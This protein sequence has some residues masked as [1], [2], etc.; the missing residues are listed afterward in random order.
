MAG[1]DD[2]YRTEHTLARDASESGSA[3][4]ASPATWFGVAI[5]GLMTVFIGLGIDAWRHNNGAGEESLLSLSNPG[6]L[7]A[8]I[9]LL[10]TSLGALGGFTASMLRGVRSAE[11]A[12][13][14]FA[15]VTAAW[16]AVAVAGIGSIVYIGASGVTVGHGEHNEAVAADASHGAPGGAAVTAE[17]AGDIANAL[18]KEGLLDD[19]TDPNAVPG[20][21]TRGATGAPGGA[22]DRGQHATFTQVSTMPAGEDLLNLFP[23]G[24]VTADNLPLLKD[25]IEQV[26]Q[27]ALQY[28]TVEAAN[29]GGFVVTTND[30]P[31]M[32]MHFLNYDNVRDG[33]F[34]P[35]KPEGLLFSKIDGGEPKLVGVWFL[36]LPGI[37]GVTREVEPAGFASDLDLWHA[38]IGLCLGGSVGASE[39]ETRESCEGK[40]GRFTA[41][42]RWMMHVWVAPEATENPAG[43]F[44]YLNNDL[45]KKQT[46]AKEAAPAAPSGTVPQ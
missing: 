1:M 29:A 39:G 27:V 46:A 16:V 11:D 38:H 33:K 42:L 40:G 34:D 41:D 10:V 14:R 6:H 19:G 43:V 5:V 24:I 20:A 15:P 23:K 31:F 13:R 26:R 21:L 32:G 17:E 28:P 45:Y 4:L 25:Q 8:G 22:H 18:E 2:A 7:I 9:G 35:S 36:L 12:I 44:A 3:W 30:V 37:G